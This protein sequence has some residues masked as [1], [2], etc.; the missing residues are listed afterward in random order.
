[1]LGRMRW[2]P[3]PALAYVGVDERG[4]SGIVV[5]DFDPNGNT[6][7]TRRAIAG[8]SNDWEVESFGVSRDGRYVTMSTISMEQSIM[9]ANGVRSVV[10]AGRES[11]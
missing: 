3:G 11:R 5:Q 2:L 9:I 7:R 8:F 1:M 4:R 6:E 10:P